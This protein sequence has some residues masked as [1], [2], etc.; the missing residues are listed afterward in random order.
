MPHPV[1]GPPSTACC[2]VPAVDEFAHAVPASR[3][4]CPPLTPCR[5]S[6]QRVRCLRADLHLRKAR[7]GH[8]NRSSRAAA[9]HRASAGCAGARRAALH[10]APPAHAYR[11]TC[12]NLRHAWAPALPSPRRPALWLPSPRGR[13]AGGEV[14]RSCGNLR[15]AW[16]IASVI[17]LPAPRGRRAGGEDL[18]SCGNLR[19]AWMAAPRWDKR[20]ASRRAVDLGSLLRLYSGT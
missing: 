14:S 7:Q 8:V 2:R 1:A 15:H 4:T 10:L 16:Q 5:C 17:G 9:A 19:Y 20:D 3:R 13:G 12:G 11:K 6:A 18:R